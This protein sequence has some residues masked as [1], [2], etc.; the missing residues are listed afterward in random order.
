M[1]ENNLSICNETCRIYANVIIERG[2]EIPTNLNL[3]SCDYFRTVSIINVLD[4]CE[5]SKNRN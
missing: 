3:E 5:K 1:A 2:I 4:E